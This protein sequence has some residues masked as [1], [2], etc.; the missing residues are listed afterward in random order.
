MRQV[1]EL[2]RVEMKLPKNLL[3]LLSSTKGHRMKIEDKIGLAAAVDLFT[4]GIV[5]MAK[6]ADIAG[7]HIYDFSV[8]LNNRG[9]A[10][11]EY[12]E[13]EYQ[14]DQEAISKYEEIKK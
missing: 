5:S 8:L 4:A 7:M 14:E 2:E 9:I 6:A 12:T 13:R 11:Y 10:A 1:A 3:L